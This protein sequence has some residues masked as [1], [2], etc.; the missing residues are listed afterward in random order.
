MKTLTIREFRRMLAGID[1][2]LSAEGEIIVARRGRPVARLLPVT[3]SRPTMPS[4]RDLRRK[5]RRMKT[6]SETLLRQE[7]DSR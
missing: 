5:M 3:G 7:R 4:H 1:A 6:G 2:L